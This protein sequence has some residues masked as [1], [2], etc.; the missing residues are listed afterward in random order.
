[1]SKIIPH[2]IWEQICQIVPHVALAILDKDGTF[3]WTSNEYSKMTGYA[4]HELK[5]LTWRDITVT[6]DVGGD[7]AALDEI[8]DGTRQN[9]YLTKEYIRKDGTAILVD[10]YVHSYPVWTKDVLL[11]I[12][13]AKPKSTEE[14]L[15]HKLEH[16]ICEIKGVISNCKGELLVLQELDSAKKGFYKYISGTIWPWVLLACSFLAFVVSTILSLYK[17]FSS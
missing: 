2:D 8:I 15:I 10:L 13:A 7:Q 11:L 16:E 5:E 4:P 17:I 1:M 3:L 6:K 12:A 14:I 9:Y